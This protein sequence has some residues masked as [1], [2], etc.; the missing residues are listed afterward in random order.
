MF[1]GLAPTINR[2]ILELKLRLRR[3]ISRSSAS[4][5]RTILELKLLLNA[6]LKSAISTINRTI[7]ELKHDSLG[8]FKVDALVY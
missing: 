1:R 7:L 2:T 4:I 5:N 3:P 8:I 6:I